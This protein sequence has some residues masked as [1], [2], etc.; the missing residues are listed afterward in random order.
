[1]NHYQHPK[2]KEV[3]AVEPFKLAKPTPSKNVDGKE[4]ILPSVK[5]AS[6]LQYEKNIADGFPAQPMTA[7]QF[8]A[9]RNPPKTPEQLAEIEQTKAKSAKLEALDSITV[10][11]SKGN[12]FD[13]NETARNNMLSAIAASEFLGRKETY[14]RMAD[15]T[16]AL[17]TVDEVRE[18]LA[19]SIARAGEI[20]VG[21]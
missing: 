12:T 11:T 5:S 2:T 6:E 4:T 13:G 20:Y 1:M 8:E 7:V 14:W 21:K 15:N 3:R 18:A 10:K 9:F 19:L 16:A 17:V